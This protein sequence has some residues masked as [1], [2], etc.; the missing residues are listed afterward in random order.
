MTEEICFT[1]K[2]NLLEEIMNHAIALPIEG[3]DQILRVAKA[4]QYTRKCMGGECVERGE[5]V[6]AVDKTED[7]MNKI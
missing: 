6:R 4:M 7:R 3:Q 2:V 5:K 1:K